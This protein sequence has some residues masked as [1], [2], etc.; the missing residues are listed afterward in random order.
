MGG[1]RTRDGL[2]ETLVERPKVIDADW[3]GPLYRQIGDGL[4]HVPVAVHDLGQGEALPLQIAAVARGAAVD[5]EVCVTAGAQGVDELLSELRD[6]MLQFPCRWRWH[7]PGLDLPATAADEFLAVR[8]DE[9]VEHDASRKLALGSQPAHHLN[10]T[11]GRAN[12]AA[13]L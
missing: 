9:V 2:V 7:R 13:R 8:S 5:V 4:T 3:F 11:T 10:P 1:H 6:P 12:V